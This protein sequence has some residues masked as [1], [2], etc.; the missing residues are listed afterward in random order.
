MTER[1]YSNRKPFHGT[2]EPLEKRL[3]FT[4]APWSAAVAA[5]S[6]AASAVTPQDD[7]IGQAGGDFASNYARERY[8]LD[9]TGQTVVIIDSGIAYDHYALGGGLGSSYRVVGGWDFA[10]NDADPY[11]DGGAGFH[12]THIA[13]IVGSSDDNYTGLASNVDLVGLRVFDDYG[14]GSFEWIESALG[15]VHNHRN[16]YPNPITTVNLSVGDNW[17]SDE[18][19]DWATLEDELQQLEH[20]G[21]FVS[22]SAGNNFQS[23][24]TIGLSYPAASESVVPVASVSNSGQMSDFSQRHDR[25]LA[26]PG[27]EITSTA[28]DYIYGFDGVTDDFIAA[29]GTSMAAPY[30]AG[31]S[32]LLREA[33][34]AMGQSN[35][36][37]HDLITI[38]RS[39]ADSVYDPI[40]N[41]NYDRI[42]LENALDSVVTNDEYGSTPSAAFGI[43]GVAESYSL[44]G[45]INSKIDQDHFAYTAEATGQLTI[46]MLWLSTPDDSASLTFND[47]TA[48]SGTTEEVVAGQTYHFAINAGSGIGRYRATLSFAAAP[49][50]VVRSPHAS[51]TASASRMLWQATSSGNYDVT[52]SIEDPA[53]VQRLEI[54]D[55]QNRIVAAVDRP[56]ADETFT[57]ATSEG[58][59][60]EIDVVGGSTSARVDFRPSVSSNSGGTPGTNAYAITVATDFRHDTRNEVHVDD[61]L[62]EYVTSE[63]PADDEVD[64]ALL[65]WQ[66][67]SEWMETMAS[68]VSIRRDTAES[69]ADEGSVEIFT[70]IADEALATDDC[71]RR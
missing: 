16:A 25:V 41:A 70:M 53:G 28:P 63:V 24:Q 14:V 1:Q 22:V 5:Y 37:Q 13:G 6:E 69:A 56:A 45:T 67:F 30:V 10:E 60:F 38:L 44:D 64:Q 68:D 48:N 51:Q 61:V 34:E 43:S 36:D 19:P 4:A 59:R 58:E 18:L 21:I 27:E 57:L 55:G 40:T 9:G 66:R 52:V 12:G 54:R 23:H 71:W 17:N 35:I 31:A 8:G 33:M 26:A 20:D 3:V 32:V 47:Q 2:V 49:T 39:T 15:W 50:V 7:S 11:D 42:N 46:D 29:S 62:I 65:G